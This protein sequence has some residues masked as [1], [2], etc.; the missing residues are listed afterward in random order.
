MRIPYFVVDSFTDKPFGGNPA[1]VCILKHW[2]E[3]SVLQNIAKEINLSETAFIVGDKSPY[4]LRWFTPGTEVDLCGHATLA[5]AHIYFEKL[6]YREESISFTTKSGILKVR[7]A[8]KLEMDL[9]LDNPKEIENTSQYANA[10][11]VKPIKAYRGISDIML[12]FENQKQIENIAFNLDAIASI[13][14]RGIIITTPGDEVDFVSRFFAPQSG[15][16]EDP[17]TGSAHATL[18]CYWAK[19]LG[20]AKMNAIQISERKGYID[21]ELKKDCVTL[22]GNAVIFSEGNIEL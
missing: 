1:G 20:K 22:A 21:C 18:T 6:N 15:I 5:T 11:G 12:V 7:K 13:E 10:F 2:P 14:T 17:V 3:D 4:Q 9:P 19:Q 16:N 8:Q